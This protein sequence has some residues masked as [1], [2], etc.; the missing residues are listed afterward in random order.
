MEGAFGEYSS[1]HYTPA[2]ALHNVYNLALELSSNIIRKS[3][4]Q[5]SQLQYSD[6]VNIG[7]Q[8][9]TGMAKELSI[10]LNSTL[11]QSQ[12]QLQLDSRAKRPKIPKRPAYY[13]SLIN[14]FNAKLHGGTTIIEGL[15]KADDNKPPTVLINTLLKRASLDI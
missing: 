1:T 3:T 15:D 5:I 4:V 6:I 12:S 14:D 10:E 11:L 2:N 8:R 9:L 7:T 13:N